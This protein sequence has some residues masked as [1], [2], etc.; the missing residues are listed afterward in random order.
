MIAIHHL[1]DYQY[2]DYNNYSTIIIKLHTYIEN[3]SPW[4]L[5][6][7]WIDY[8]SQ[9]GLSKAKSVDKIIN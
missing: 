9:N 7:T 6:R 3:D 4:F 2:N 1:S 5:K 8:I